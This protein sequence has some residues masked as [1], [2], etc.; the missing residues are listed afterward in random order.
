MA[1]LISRF[2]SEGMPDGIQWPSLKKTDGCRD[3]G[4]S[5]I[6]TEPIGALRGLSFKGGEWAGSAVLRLW[7]LA[8]IFPPS[9]D[10][11]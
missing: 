5:P 6:A 1:I 10:G 7:P 11:L 9:F 2:S 3:G 8:R 4:L